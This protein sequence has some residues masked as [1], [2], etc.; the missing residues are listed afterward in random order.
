MSRSS[1]VISTALL[2]AY[3]MLGTPAQD[4]YQ[5]P[6]TKEDSLRKFLQDY[7]KRRLVDGK[8][9]RYLYA[10]VDLSG[11]GKQEIVTYI[12]GDSWCGSGG[13]TTL[14][15]APQDSSYRI[16]TRIPIT[17]LPIRILAAKSNGWHDLG[18]WVQGGGIQ[19]GYEAEL[20]FDGKSYP[21]NPSRL[22][23]R[24]LTD[25]AKGDVILSPGEV[26]ILLS[27]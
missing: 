18:V 17:G 14:V 3:L 23:A 5:S 16:V 8:T 10:F 1:H 4:R 15:L 7:V 26:G 27:Q 19:P 11:N 24:R 22:P 12:T 20:S 6:S 21:T 25:G 2:V 13:C 9:T